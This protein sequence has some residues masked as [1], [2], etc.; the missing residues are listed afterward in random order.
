[1]RVEELVDYPS[2]VPSGVVC[3]QAYSTPAFLQ[4]SEEPDICSSVFCPRELEYERSGASSTEDVESA[5]LVVYMCDGAAAF[6][7]PTTHNSRQQSKCCFVFCRNY[8]AFF[9]VT[10]RQHCSLFLKR[11]TSALSGALWLRG[12]G[13]CKENPATVKSSQT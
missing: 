3:K 8:E 4:F 9:T 1:M 10:F 2:L 11:S 6:L 13:V 7:R 12:L 5:V